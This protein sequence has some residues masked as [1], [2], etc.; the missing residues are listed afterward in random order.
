MLLHFQLTSPGSRHNPCGTAEGPAPGH[1]LRGRSSKIT[2][3]AC[4][5]APSPPKANLFDLFLTLSLQLCSS[6]FPP[7]VFLL[8]EQHP[9]LCSRRGVSGSALVLRDRD[10]NLLPP[11]ACSEKSRAWDGA[12][13]TRLAGWR[14]TCS[15]ASKSPDYSG[16]PGISPCLII[17]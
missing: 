4:R 11:A 9:P 3:A 12:A 1:G 2:A 6:Y 5:N 16:M 15:P 10:I 7:G 8:R 17:V 14:R 13:E